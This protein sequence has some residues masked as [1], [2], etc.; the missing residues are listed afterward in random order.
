[1]IH[2]PTALWYHYIVDLLAWS[3]ASLGARW[4][5]LHHRQSVEVLAR[6]TAPSYFV[7]LAVGGA[8]GAWL[9]GSLNTLRDTRP[10]LSHSIAGALAGAIV[11]VELWKRWRGVRSS[12]GG[13]FVI[14]LSL[15]ILVGRWGCLFAGIGDQTY[16][17]PA[18]LPWSVELGDGVARHPVQIYESLGMALF[19]A[20]YWRAL[21]RRQTW[22]ERN[23]FHV[24][25]LAYA[26]QRFAW[27][28]LKPYPTLIGPLNVFHFVMI[29]L[30][31]YALL[32]IANGQRAHP[33][34]RA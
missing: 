17:I 23:G 7:S 26:A 28:F 16:G 32:W 4:F 13:P 27:E 22:A 15:G 14:P 33:A 34:G 11:A 18:N 6:Q 2:I 24:F 5:Y 10:V 12:T 21:V 1:M 25:V 3:T 29:G 30:C 19:L 8:I 31:I 9:L 20:V